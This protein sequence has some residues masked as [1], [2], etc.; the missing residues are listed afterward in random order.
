MLYWWKFFSCWSNLIQS[1]LYVCSASWKKLCSFIFLKFSFDHLF[2][3]RESG[4]RNYCFGKSLV[5]WIQESVRTLCIWPKQIILPISTENS[6]WCFLLWF[7]LREHQGSREKR[8]T[9]FL[10]VS[11]LLLSINML[12]PSLSQ[13]TSSFAFSQWLD[14]TGKF[15]FQKN[16]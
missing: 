5:F 15:L 14:P 1:H 2:D 10:R 6:K 8:I 12:F 13:W 4:K 11:H 16:V 3:N 7:H 9:I